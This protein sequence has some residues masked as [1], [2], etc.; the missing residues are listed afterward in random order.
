MPDGEE[1]QVREIGS[2]RI[3]FQGAFC[4]TPEILTVKGNTMRLLVLADNNTL[5]DR[6][7]LGEPAAC[8]YLEDGDARILLDAGY[9]DV[10]IRNAETLG[11]DLAA[12]AHV[13]I[14]H[15]HNDHTRGLAFLHGHVGPKRL[16]V[17]AHPDAF[18]DR[19]E[20]GLA[21]GCPL[22]RSFLEEKYDLTLTKEPFALSEH[23][24]FL[25]EIPRYN[26]FERSKPVGTLREKDGEKPDFVPDDTALACMTDRGLFV[27]TGCSH[28]GICNIIEHARHVCG[29]DRVLGVVGGFHLFG[30]T[31]QLR[32]TVRYFEENDIRNL[33]PCHCVSFAAKAEIHKRIPI[34]EVGAGLEI[35]L[36]AP[37]W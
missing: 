28:S 11:L 14:S 7:Y 16:S 23:I 25:G 20:D 5:I 4:Q 17:V 33:Y 9:S 27:V 15:G 1:R 31:E 18:A 22:E 10:F 8:Y 2:R 32:K 3:A 6:Y 19:H 12:L 36:R 35:P 34:H 37:E 24:I 13:A 30:V 26:D 29:M 21:I